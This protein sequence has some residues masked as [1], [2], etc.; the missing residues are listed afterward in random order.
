MYIKSI[1][2][3]SFGMLNNF[4]LE[5]S[6]GLNI[7][8]G[9][10]ETG[11]STISAFI[12]F[13]FYGLSAKKDSN[14][15]TDRQRYISWKTGKAAGSLVLVSDREYIIEREMFSFG[16]QTTKQTE[17]LKIV[18]KE[19]LEIIKADKEQPGELFF[20]MPEEVFV[21]T[22]FIGQL[23]DAKINADGISEAIENMLLTGD[24]NVNAQKASA[25]LDKL[26]TS[27]RYVKGQGGKLYDLEREKARLEENLSEAKVKA[28]DV[29]ELE[30]AVLD[31]ENNIKSKEKTFSRYKE[32]SDAYKKVSAERKIREIRRYAADI[33]KIDD[34]IAEYEKYGS[35]TEKEIEIQRL[36]SSIENIDDRLFTLRNKMS[37][38]ESTIPKMDE[39]DI[40]EARAEVEE[41]YD[42]SAKKGK[43]LA[44]GIICL[45]IM[46]G[47]IVANFFIPMIPKYDIWIH[48]ACLGLAGIFAIIG[49]LSILN[50]VK[51][52]NKLKAI[53]EKWEVDS[54][55]KLEVRVENAIRL[56]KTREIPTSDYCVTASA[57]EKT[58]QEKIAATAALSDICT[59]FCS[60]DDD[61]SVMSSNAISVADNLSREL[62]S[63][64]ETRKEL[65]G[66]YSVL[67][68][69]LGEDGGES[70]DK[71]YYD[72]IE[73]DAGAKA[74]EMTEEE[75]ENCE[76]QYKFAEA[77]LPKL[78][79]Q[80]NE[81]ES[82]LSVIRTT[83][84]EPS[85]VSAQ[86][87]AVISEYEKLSKKFSSVVLA[88][89]VIKI[90]Q[91]NI[92]QSFLPR[93]SSQAGKL[94][95]NFSNGK[96]ENLSLD[97][98]FSVNYEKAG[99]VNN[100][101]QLSSGTM[102]I[103]YVAVRL[104]LL[105]VL[106]GEKFPTCVYDESFARV[107][108]NRLASVLDILSSG[109]A[110]QSILFTCR[111]LECE[112]A[113]RTGNATVIKLNTGRN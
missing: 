109:I 108:E 32:L 34:K 104:S 23:S 49:A 68:Y 11:K 26:R 59:L 56:S 87:D 73:T 8:E 3:D 83:T 64:K 4:D 27:L 52:S 54:D 35:I 79:E 46:V 113:E 20:G 38:L 93:V 91:N 65:Y 99:R 13:I 25:K 30:T 5:L 74:E 15:I 12:K 37:D 47:L 92:R 22:S 29:I 28:A 2:I 45:I 36:S 81:K 100:A 61:Y 95:Y 55:G 80:K 53:L 106:F 97:A 42:C 60:P 94:L 101:V 17:K 48:S 75:F 18:D 10:N 103:V 16:E 78:R 98:N 33:D 44:W 21:N 39:N 102:D 84:V 63:L 96:Y 43:N 9:D 111:S 6:K 14:G 82:R 40:N 107:D 77:A 62:S 76:K 19:T 71:A 66:K 7:I 58:T 90:A 89:E 88:S 85:V 1:H 50:S 24:E 31:L 110:Q 57:L 67:S 41:A 51:R 105:D 112:I 70:I 72:V 69:I 86:L